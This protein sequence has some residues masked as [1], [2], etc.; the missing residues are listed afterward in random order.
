MT[1]EPTKKLLR[2]VNEK[3][4]SQDDSGNRKYPISIRR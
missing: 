1:A 3:S 4:D 2:S